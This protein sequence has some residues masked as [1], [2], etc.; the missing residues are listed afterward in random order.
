MEPD[1]FHGPH[2]Q[3]RPLPADRGAPPRPGGDARAVHLYAAAD[4]AGAG[5]CGLRRL[6]WAVDA[7]GCGGGDRVGVVSAL[8]RAGGE[9]GVSAQDVELVFSGFV[10]N[11]AR[12]SPAA[13]SV[14][15]LRCHASFTRSCH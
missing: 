8:S 5:I 4:N 14:A 11:G 6:A 7:G 3:R 1:D 2:R 12:L 10:V 15:L 9:G 13:K